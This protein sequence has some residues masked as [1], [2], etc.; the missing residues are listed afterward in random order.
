MTIPLSLVTLGF[1]LL[2]V[3]D[4]MTYP[5]YPLSDAMDAEMDAESHATGNGER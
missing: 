5:P 3:E 4:T 2:V 1:A